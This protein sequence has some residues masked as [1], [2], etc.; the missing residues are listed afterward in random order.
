MQFGPQVHEG[1]N[2]RDMSAACASKL[3]ESCLGRLLG[4]ST[5][6][7]RG[8]QHP[9]VSRFGDGI[10]GRAGMIGLGIYCG[11][12]RAA[13]AALFVDSL[14]A[15][16]HDPHEGLQSFSA[17]G[18][19]DATPFE[20]NVFV[21]QQV[22]MPVVLHRHGFKRFAKERGDAAE[23]ADVSRVSRPGAGAVATVAAAVFGSAVAVLPLALPGRASQIQRVWRPVRER[24][25]RQDWHCDRGRPRRLTTSRGPFDPSWC[26]HVEAR[27]P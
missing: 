9:A 27:W 11:A 23:A 6:A 2:G 14:H 20:S 10:A 16:V 24:F 13:R 21:L 22:Q 5:S 12:E 1:L 25:S 18:L 26:L 4:R 17:L 3:I 8:R 7:T 15:S 19:H